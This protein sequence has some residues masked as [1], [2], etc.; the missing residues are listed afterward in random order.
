MK[1]LS[2]LAAVLALGLWTTAAYGDGGAILLHRDA[3]PFTIT[4]FAA[5]QPLAT[6][7]A[8]VSVMVQDRGSGDVLLDPTIDVTFGLA[9]TGGVQQTVRLAPRKSGNR[10]LQGANLEFA[11]AGAWHVTVVV[12]RGNYVAQV[13]TECTVEAN[14]SRAMLVWFY[15][16][17]PVGLIL[18]FILHQ[19]LK[20]NQAKRPR[21]ADT[22]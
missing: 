14:S 4:L 13:S 15:V 19:A 9:G 18:I 6:G 3:G 10:M 2:P 20:Q 21:A 1:A 7:A 22:V 11:K 17:L 5:P 8:D 12:H 16:L